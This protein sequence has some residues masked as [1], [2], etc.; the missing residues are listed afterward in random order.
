MKVLKHGKTY[1]VVAC[2]HC[3]AVL[4]LNHKD[5]VED[6]E[7]DEFSDLCAFFKYFTCPECGKKTYLELKVI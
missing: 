2:E 7:Y 6:F 5:I 3:E 1:A 4:E